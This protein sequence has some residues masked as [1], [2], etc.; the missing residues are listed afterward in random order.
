MKRFTRLSAVL[1]FL[2]AV[3]TM[4]GCGD[5]NHMLSP[6]APN[7]VTP[8]DTVIYRDSCAFVRTSVDSLP[9]NTFTLN[10]AGAVSSLAE[11]I[12]LQ[13]EKNVVTIQ[14]HLQYINPDHVTSQQ[15]SC[16]AKDVHDAASQYPGL[17][18]GTTQT[19]LQL[20]NRSIDTLVTVRFETG[21]TMPSHGTYGFYLQWKSAGTAPITAAQL[22][23]RPT[24]ATGTECYDQ[25]S[26]EIHVECY[27]WRCFRVPVRH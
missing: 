16:W 21:S 17:W 23:V 14:L 6:V 1:L 11:A 3:I 10:G 13:C 2:I 24:G 4:T 27:D 19:T 9:T 26:G 5:R 18:N 7:P 25:G 12:T 20:P 15:L 22:S 8:P